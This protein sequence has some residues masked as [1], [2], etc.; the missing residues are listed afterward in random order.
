M[1]RTCR[2]EKLECRSLLAS[3]WQASHNNYDVD[4]SGLV[5]ASDAVLVIDDLNENGFRELPLHL[6]AGYSG[7]LCDVNGDGRMTP[8]D[9][10]AVIDLLNQQ[11][12]LPEIN[13]QLSA[14]SDLNG[15]FFV[16]KPSVAY[17]LTGIPRAKIVFEKLA[18]DIV[19]ASEQ[20]LL[21]EVGRALIP[22]QLDLGINNF[23]FTIQN[24]RGFTKSVQRL[25]RYGDAVLQWN[26]AM[27][28]MVRETTKVGTTGQ[29]K[30]PPPLVAKHLAMMH[31]AIFDA[32]NAVTG[33]HYLGQTYNQ[34]FRQASPVAA[35]SA[36]AYSIASQLY[37]S[38]HQRQKWDHT[39]TEI[40]TTIPDDAARSAG[41]AI[42]LQAAEAMMTLRAN[43]GSSAPSTFQVQETVGHWQPTLPSYA[44]A[45]LPHWPGVTPFGLTSSDQFRAPAPPALDSAEYAAAVDEVMR[46]G[47]ATSQLRTED[48]T[49]IAKFWADEAGTA[50]P[51]GHWN[52]IAGDAAAP[53]QLPI[54][55]NARLFALLNYA[56]ADAGIACWDT[57]YSFD[58]WRP[59]DAIRKAD[60]DGNPMTSADPNWTPLLN[61]P[62]FPAYTSGHSTFSGAGAA[63][64]SSVLGSNTTFT[65][66]IDPG[67]SAAATE[68]TLAGRTFDSFQ[69]AADQAGSSRIYGGIHYNFDHTFGLT[70]GNSIGTWITNQ[71]LQPRAVN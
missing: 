27:L 11:T 46:L 20:H 58:L 40:L 3:V 19:V 18:G 21:N 6:P 61:T 67:S 52:T 49:A 66:W 60:L 39:L 59:I 33:S 65:A 70:A 53:R 13:V 16:V 69:A 31:G 63:V 50:T 68:S 17:E 55:E 35:A 38:D 48:Q 29:L 14:A 26:A 37:F 25:T 43:D 23:R 51:P 42:G 64:L 71:L 22:V 36:A 9:A 1:K 47:S 56:L 15:D 8:A 44:A 10:L 4:N 7:A 54:I 24:Q 57:K 62:P 32:V 41:L 28:D 34:Q 45:V 5:V 12:G 2:F 30:P